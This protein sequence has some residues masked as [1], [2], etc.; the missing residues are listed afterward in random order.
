M[1]NIFSMLNMLHLFKM[2]HI[3]MIFNMFCCRYL[4][5]KSPTFTA[6]YSAAIGTDYRIVDFPSRIDSSRLVKATSAPLVDANVDYYDGSIGYYMLADRPTQAIAGLCSDPNCGM[7]ATTSTPQVLLPTDLAAVRK[8][9][10]DPS[11]I[12]NPT[13]RLSSYDSLQ[14]TSPGCYPIVATIDFTT[15]TGASSYC[16]MVDDVVSAYRRL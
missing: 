11:T 6:A 13:A 10:S 8:C 2:L 14:S 4:S 7:T 16:N 9:M 3:F 12:V 5:Y 15:F 1:L